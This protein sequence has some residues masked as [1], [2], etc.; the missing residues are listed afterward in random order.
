MAV[1]ADHEELGT[2][3]GDLL[4]RGSGA[5]ARLGAPGRDR[6]VLHS[7]KDKSFEYRPTP[8]PFTEYVYED[9]FRR[10]TPGPEWQQTVNTGGRGSITNPP[11][12]DLRGRCRFQ[13]GAVPGDILRYDFGGN[14]EFAATHD[15]WLWLA[16]RL[17]NYD[18]QKVYTWGL[19]D[20][21]APAGAEQ[22]QGS[23][24]VLT[25]DNGFYGDDFYRLRVNDNNPTAQV[26]STSSMAAAGGDEFFQVRVTGG[27][28]DVQVFVGKGAG[29]QSIIAQIPS[30]AL[31]PVIYLQ[32][33]NGAPAILD[34]D[35]WLLW[36]E[37]P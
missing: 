9:H 28:T 32:T 30:A 1:H 8:Q 17:V 33:L 36:G 11:A 7:L 16:F 25:V 20:G 2:T 3:K 23:E 13:T 14:F 34:M 24:I 26:V 15:V 35:Y 22:L 19:V 37:A 12:N 6:E 21:A 5:F 4:V 10:R 31:Q 18:A 29:G 27:A